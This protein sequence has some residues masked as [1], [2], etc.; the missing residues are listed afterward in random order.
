MIWILQVREMRSHYGNGL[1][2]L[3]ICALLERALVAKNALRWQQCFF[4]THVTLNIV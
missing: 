4:F 2:V 1:V 3:R